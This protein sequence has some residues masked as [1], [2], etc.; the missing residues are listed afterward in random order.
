MS[1]LEMRKFQATNRK[2]N[3]LFPRIVYE[4]FNKRSKKSYINSHV[5]TLRSYFLFNNMGKKG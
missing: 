3:L 5:D 1:V 2:W 4:E